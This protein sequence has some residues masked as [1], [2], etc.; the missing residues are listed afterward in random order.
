[1]SRARECRRVCGEMYD[2][3]ANLV[4]VLLQM[5]LHSRKLVEAQNAKEVVNVD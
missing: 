3:V 2:L 5:E 1:M 4:I